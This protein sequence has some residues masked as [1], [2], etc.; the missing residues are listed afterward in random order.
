M[1]LELA[2]YQAEREN[3]KTFL[4]YFEN[5]YQ[6]RPLTIKKIQEIMDY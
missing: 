4:E 2:K 1:Y 3:V 5:Y 6:E